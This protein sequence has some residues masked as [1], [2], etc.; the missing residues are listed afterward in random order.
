MRKEDG[1]FIIKV[2]YPE[3]EWVY[4]YILSFGE[5]IKVLSPIKAKNIIKDKLEKTL[6]NY[7]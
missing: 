2:K 1:N 5:H 3:N 6:K 4:G 7:L